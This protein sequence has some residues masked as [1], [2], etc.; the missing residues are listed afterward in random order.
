MK[1]ILLELNEI[2]FDFVKEYIASGEKLLGFKKLLDGNFIHTIS[3]E[4]YEHLEPWIQW[5]S[6]HTGKKYTD[7]KIFRLEILHLLRRNKFLK[8]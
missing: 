5:V 3:E 6:V 1:L 4:K 2:N 8:L 7:H